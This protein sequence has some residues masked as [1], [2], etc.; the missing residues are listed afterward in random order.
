M[1]TDSDFILAIKLYPELYQIDKENIADAEERNKELWSQFARD[2]QLKNGTA[3]KLKWSQII[4]QYVSFLMY[5]TPFHFEKEMQFM[6]MPLLGAG[7]E[8]NQS[9]SDIDETELRRVL[10]IFEDFPT[11]IIKQ[12]IRTSATNI[13]ASKKRSL[14]K[15]QGSELNKADFVKFN[16]TV[17][18]TEKHYETDIL[19]LNN[20]NKNESEVKVELAVNKLSSKQ[21]G[22]NTMVSTENMLTAFTATTHAQAAI[23]CSEDTG[24]PGGFSS[25][26]SLELIF[27]GYAKVLQRMPLRLQLQTK[28]KIADIMDEAEL[29]LFED[30]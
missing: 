28:R 12:N 22:L 11:D 19:D 3:A 18:N 13:I 24:S 2:H 15:G 17:T 26:T 20:Y 29:K 9:D 1:I 30:K 6:Q 14:V 25:L 8:D 10:K 23:K 4:S 7:L 27:L 21:N 16:S 5:G